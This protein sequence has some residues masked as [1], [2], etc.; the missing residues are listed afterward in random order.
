MGSNNVFLKEAEKRTM[1]KILSLAS[2][3]T[4]T[5]ELLSD[6]QKT[7]T[8]LRSSD[9]LLREYLE[10]KANYARLTR[11]IDEAIQ[12]HE[13][14]CRDCGEKHTL[15]TVA[16]MKTVPMVVLRCPQPTSIEQHPLN[17]AEMR[18]LDRIL[19]FVQGEAKNIFGT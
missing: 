8:S 17:T 9:E 13:I 1:E 10:L 15:G 14:K 19:R 6:C 2:Q 5:E 16:L 3:M 12:D 7:Y 18:S 11:E 4:Q